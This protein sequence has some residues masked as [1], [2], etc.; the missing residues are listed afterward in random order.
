MKWLA[1]SLI[2]AGLAFGAQA[3]EMARDSDLVTS[4]SK[5]EMRYIIESAN[6]TVKDD[7]STGVGFVGSDAND[8]VFGV[9]GKA[10]DEAEGDCVGLEFFLVLEGDFSNDYANDVNQRWSAVKAT[11]L[12]EGD[13][14]LSRYVIL[15][16]G[17][18]LENLRLN[19]M[20]T[21]A[22]AM[23]VREENEIPHS[24]ASASNGIPQ[25]PASELEWGD[26]T[27]DY[28]NDSACDD[29]RFHSDGDDWSYQRNHVLHDAND[30]RSL[31]EAGEITLY[32][33]FGNNSGEYADDNTC[34]DNRFTGEGRS[35]LTT[36]SHVKRDAADCI[37]A[38]RAGRLDRP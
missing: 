13:L 10:C 23:Q 1:T 34:D 7:L 27:G 17:Q 25:V 31:Y 3:Q 28:A 19:L 4:V 18:T 35:I 26:N 24:E 20:T 11:K 14:M 5:T 33:D 21:R 22:I 29:A 9:Q 2:A 30:C 12:D 32:L 38:Y 16:H 6:F 15:D 8:L 37:A 36:D